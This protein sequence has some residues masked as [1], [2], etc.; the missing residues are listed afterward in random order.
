MVVVSPLLY[1]HIAA[2]AGCVCVL[3]GGERGARVVTANFTE[4]ARGAEVVEAGSM[5]VRL[6]SCYNKLW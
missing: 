4:R 1:R 3:Q 5:A 2:G 6:T